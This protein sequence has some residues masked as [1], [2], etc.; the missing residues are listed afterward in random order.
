MGQNYQEEDEAEYQYYCE[1]C[2]KD[3]KSEN[4][5]RNHEKSKQHKQ[6]VKQIQREVMLK[7]DK[8]EE[9]EKKEE[10]PEP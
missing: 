10:E 7:E 8:Q 6:M 2:S 1:I 4:Q 3:F 5:L 9:A